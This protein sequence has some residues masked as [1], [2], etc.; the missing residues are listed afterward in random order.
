[1]TCDQ[2]LAE[3]RDL[4]EICL[5]AINEAISENPDLVTVV[6]TGRTFSSCSGTTQK[7]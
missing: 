7:P 4:K 3:T 5:D 6:A 1:M 2:V